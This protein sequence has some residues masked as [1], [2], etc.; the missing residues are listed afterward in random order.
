MRV[1]IAV[2]LALAAMVPAEAAISP[3]LAARPANGP[4]TLKQGITPLGDGGFAY[5]PASL[6]PG[7]RPLIVL[8]RGAL[9]TARDPINQFKNLADKNGWLLLAPEAADQTWR[10]RQGRDG[11]IDFGMDPPRIDAALSRMF[12]K[13]PV[14]PKRV[15][16][17]GFS[18]GASY[19]LS[20]GTANPGLFRSIVALSPGYTAVPRRVDPAQR[21]FI[22]HGTDDQILPPDNVRTYILPDLQT[23]GL[24]PRIR[25]FNGGHTID[26]A[27]LDEALVYALEQP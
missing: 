27:A 21:I 12:A 17:L 19:A 26:R 11:G 14:D 7:P 13:A 4:M 10:V 24:K 18:D 16:L 9:G 15:V 2:T 5:R 3:A 25:W 1:A 20:L 22:A 6:P 8:L 23:A